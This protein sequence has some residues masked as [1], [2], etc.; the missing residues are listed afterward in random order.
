MGTVPGDSSVKP[1][2]IRITTIQAEV[3]DKQ[4]SSELVFGAGNNALVN[5]TLRARY[6]RGIRA[7]DRLIN[8]VSDQV[9]HIE[10]I[11][12]ENLANRWML[13]TAVDRDGET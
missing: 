12:N 3:D 8:S 5:H 11:I 4:S 6:Q 10:G 2:W 9:L 13:I 7:S 1:V